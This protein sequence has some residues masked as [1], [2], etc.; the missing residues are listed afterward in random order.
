MTTDY[1]PPPSPPQSFTDMESG[2]SLADFRKSHITVRNIDGTILPKQPRFERLREIEDKRRRIL[3]RM[4]LPAWRILFFRSGTCLRGLLEDPIMW[5]SIAAY[6]GL[7][8]AARLDPDNMAEAAEA[9]QN[10]TISVVGGFLSFFLVL[11]VN[12]TNGRFFE[13]YGFSKACAGRTQDIAGLASTQFPPELANQIVRHMNAAHVAGYVGLGTMYSERHFFDHFNREWNLLTD[14]EL[15]Q[16]AIYDW[17]EGADVMKDLVT[18]C[19][20]D[21]GLAK[22][23][24]YIDS[25]E[26]NEMH[27]TI[28]RFRA[29]MD[30]IYDYCD[31][32]PHFFYVHFLC[33]LSAIYLPIFAID[34]AYAAGI[35]DGSVWEIEILNLV[36]V[37]L[38]CVF[39]IGLRSLGQKMVDPY[40]H[41]Y[42]D[43]S[44][45]TYVETTLHNCRIITSTKGSYLNDE[46]AT[47]SDEDVDEP[48]KTLFVVSA[49]NE[50]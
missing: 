44:V 12:Q 50:K 11:F 22:K 45:L 15:D 19:Q 1:V 16:L 18:W 29:S 34:N 17:E 32:P 38:Q 49:N 42:E 26:A 14:E 47:S 6:I 43:L 36:I 23:L 9:M 35:G 13:M 4:E 10:S 21:V 37:F 46:R 3:N 25:Y 2:K 8:I 20:R 39:V 30:G 7:R 28:L 33:W 48:S 31:Q 40:G 5:I 24:G 27:Q 41:D